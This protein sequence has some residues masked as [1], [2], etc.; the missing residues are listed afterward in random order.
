MNIVRELVKRN[1]QVTLF[2]P[3]YTY[4]Q[5]FKTHPDG[6]VIS[7]GPCDP[8]DNINQIAQIK[9]MIDKDLPILGICLGHQMIGLASGFDTKKLKYGHR[10]ANHP[11]TYVDKKS[12]LTSQNHGYY[13]D[14]KTV[15]P[16]KVIISFI[17]N[18]DHSVEGMVFKNK[19]YIETTQFHPEACAGPRDTNFIFDNFVNALKKYAK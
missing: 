16:K 17:N 9:K 13:I 6:F 10:G 5:M 19:K 12:Y 3:N 15:D 11:C 2:P 18:N 7:N 14:N 8:K 1:C 4:E